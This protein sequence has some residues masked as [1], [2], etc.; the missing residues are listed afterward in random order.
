MDY[1]HY[2]V[3]VVDGG[4]N[5]RTVSIAEKWANKVIVDP[6]LPKGWVGKCYGCHLGSKEAI[7]DILLFTDADTEHSPESLKVFVG[8]LLG[9]ESVML[10][11]LPYQKAKRWYEYLV[12]FYFF[13]S[14]LAGGPLS[15]ISNPYKKDAF[16][17]IG[18]Y[19]LFTREGYEK[20]GGHIA[21]NNSIVEDVA[22]AKVIKERQM[23]MEFIPSTKL[24]TCRMYPDGF[25]S[26][27]NGF[28]KSIYGGLTALP[29]WRIVFIV[30]WIIYAFIA[31]YFVVRAILQPEASYLEIL[32]SILTFILFAGT[33]AWYW[34]DKGDINWIMITLYP[35]FLAID[36]GIILIS[37]YKGIKGEPVQ[38]K[39]RHYEVSITPE[40]LKAP[41][42]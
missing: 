35:L 7:G 18:Q 25:R 36:I 3:I 5:D 19:L 9:K 29:I 39:N 14:F 41:K 10:S 2:E 23:K 34:K 17:A 16:M 8:Q 26:F 12:S 32:F 33:I 6:S 15:E 11:L 31:P 28:K 40:D 21:V 13:F 30:M 42:E 24:V 20:I 37:I 4:S 27:Y 38:W 22:F 1:P